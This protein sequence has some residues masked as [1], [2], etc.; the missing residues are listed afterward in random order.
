MSVILTKY[1][2]QLDRMAEDVTQD[3]FIQWKSHPVTIQLMNDLMADYIGLL[4]DQRVISS[5]EDIANINATQGRLDAIDSILEWS[6]I[7]ESEEN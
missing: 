5:P 6:P 4:E 1:R 2:E 3:D 7:D